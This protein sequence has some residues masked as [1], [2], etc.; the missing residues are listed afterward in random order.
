[1]QS[2]GL[3][4]AKASINR[5][6]RTVFNNNIPSGIFLRKISQN[7]G[8]SYQYIQI[9][10]DQAS[11]IND[12]GETKVIQY[13]HGSDTK[14][15]NK[16][17]KEV[18]PFITS[19]RFFPFS[20]D[21]L[22]LNI[23]KFEFIQS[24]FKKLNITSSPGSILILS[25]EMVWSRFIN[26]REMLNIIIKLIKGPAY[27]LIDY[28]G[29]WQS[30]VSKDYKLL[31]NLKKKYLLP[32]LLKIE[33]PSASIDFEIIKENTRKLLLLSEDNLFNLK[34]GPYYYNDSLVPD[35]LL[36]SKNRDK[37]A[38][39]KFIQISQ[40]ISRDFPVLFTG[41]SQNIF[42]I[43]QKDVTFKAGIDQKCSKKV[44][45]WVDVNETIGSYSEV[46][47]KAYSFHKKTE[48][49]VFEGQLVK[50]GDIILIDRK[51]NKVLAPFQAKI[52]LKLSDSGVLR[53]LR[54][55]LTK[56]VKSPFKGILEGF[57]NKDGYAIEASDCSFI[58]M[59]YMRGINMVGVLSKEP[60]AGSIVYC[61][62]YAEFLKI[63][64]AN[65]WQEGKYFNNQLNAII[66]KSVSVEDFEVIEK[67]PYSKLNLGILDVGS[68]SIKVDLL[69]I[70]IGN[71]VVLTNEGLLFNDKKD[72]KR[73]QI[74]IIDN[75]KGKEV[76]AW[77]LEGKLIY[78]KIVSKSLNNPNAFLVN[79][80]QGYY[81]CNLSNIILI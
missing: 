62:S 32:K 18:F 21:E 17:E 70:Y 4:I 33:V 63:Y 71:L 45:D 56:P 64:G 19:L 55:T 81:E 73:S 12:I 51:G 23:S 3:E 61:E 65:G 58:P 30:L 25:G 74:N 77:D 60:V 28:Y 13:D 66:I 68:K 75:F 69:D 37:E 10:F 2:S 53:L 29:I 38:G 16:F 11:Y 67:L 15:L 22:F 43:S 76:K 59:D 47:F 48:L 26:S 34:D 24:L 52:D 80:D 79:S 44:G 14:S 78:G 31:K 41:Y 8:M 6:R 42:N 40:D 5:H 72:G 7:L 49:R 35:W 9:D 46:Q 20:N 1:V 50:K 36:I 54:Q 39:K 57:S 27:L